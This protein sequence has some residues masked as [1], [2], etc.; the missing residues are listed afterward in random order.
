VLVTGLVHDNVEV[1]RVQVLVNGVE[2]PSLLDVG[3]VGRGVPVGALAELK[4]G[5]NVIEVTATDKAGNVA[6]V[7]RNVTRITAA[8][9]A[10]ALG[11]KIANRW[12]VIIG[13]GD[14]ESKSVPKPRFA[15]SD[16]DAMYR[17]LTS[18]GGYPR[19]NVVLLTDKGAREA[20]APE[21][22]PGARRF[23][24]AQDRA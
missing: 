24:R 21:H 17:L 12:A 1:A 23:P 13:V 20:D 19:E 11:P 4:P 2:A 22:P 7:V 8:G 14:Y 6:Q 16:A 15:D 9:A 18:R 10:A 5:P 3:V